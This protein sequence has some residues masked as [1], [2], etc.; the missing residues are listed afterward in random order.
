MITR[1]QRLDAIGTRHEF[2]ILDEHDY[3]LLNGL[4]TCAHASSATAVMFV[5]WAQNDTAAK[6]NAQLHIVCVNEAA[7]SSVLRVY[8]VCFGLTPNMD[9]LRAPVK[10]EHSTS[11]TSEFLST[12]LHCSVQM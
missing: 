11:S 2:E 5:C 7:T 12:H 9:T 8:D 6:A 3:E 10:R 1:S 4:D